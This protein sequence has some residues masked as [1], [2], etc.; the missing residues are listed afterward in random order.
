M[1]V[2]GQMVLFPLLFR[3]TMLMRGDVM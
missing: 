2:P 1:L 3:N